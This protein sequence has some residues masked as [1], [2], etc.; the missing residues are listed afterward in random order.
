[1]KALSLYRQAIEKDPTYARAYAGIADCYGVLGSAGFGMMRPSEAFPQAKA[2]AQKALAIDDSLAEAHASLGGCALMYDWDWAAAERS[3]QKAVG[4]DPENVTTRLLYSQFLAITGRLED[5]EREAR[6]VADSD[7]L[8]PNGP[9]W[10]AVT[11]Y[12]RRRYDEALQAAAKALELDPHFVPAHLVVLSTYQSQGRLADAISYAES[13]TSTVKLP[14]FIATKGQ[15]YGFAH[16]LDDAHAALEELKQLSTKIY[17]SPFLFCII[18]YGI[19]D[20]Q[21]WEAALWKAY[22]E[23]ANGLVFIKVSPLFDPIRSEPIYE[24]L[25][26]KIGLP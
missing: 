16:R 11:L 7:P 3:L 15:L 24:E 6:R 21:A 19:G 5:A 9:G 22:E 2:A 4:L 18:Y 17:V 20:R 25:V 10:L 1:M 23:R 8:F 14:L 13:I 12:S 26:R